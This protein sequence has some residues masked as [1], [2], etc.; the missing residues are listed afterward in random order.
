MWPRFALVF[1]WEKLVQPQS[2]NDLTR[3][4]IFF[5]GWFSFK[6]ND[7]RLALGMTLKFY[8]SVEKE[9]KIS[10]KLCRCHKK[11]RLP[12]IETPQSWFSGKL[13]LRSLV[14]PVN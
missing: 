2:Y 12:R 13:G 11:L 4:T 10:Q 6:F 1:L 5:E 3:K 9:L 14:L 8:A 7:L